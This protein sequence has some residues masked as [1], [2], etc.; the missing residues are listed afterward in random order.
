M[1]WWRR[2]AGVMVEIAKREGIA[3]LFQG[4]PSALLL[5]SNPAIQFLVYERLKS[6]FLASA[7]H[8]VRL[9]PRLRPCLPL[10]SLINTNA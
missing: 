5:C 2:C 3:A 7:K 8:L 10:Q 4:V 1:W 9:E 6:R